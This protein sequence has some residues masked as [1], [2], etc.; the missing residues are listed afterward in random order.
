[1]Q[2][3]PQ[4]K[5]CPLSI[6]AWKEEGVCIGPPTHPFRHDCLCPKPPVKGEE[7]KV[8]P[9]HGA[10]GIEPT[11]YCKYKIGESCI[12]V[13]ICDRPAPQ[14]TEGEK[15][16]K[17]ECHHNPDYEHDEDQYQDEEHFCPPCDCPPQVK[18]TPE[19]GKECEEHDYDNTIRLGRARHICP[20]CGKNV[21]LELAL[22]EEALQKSSSPQPESEG[23]ETERLK[24]LLDGELISANA[25]ASFLVVLDE[26][27][28]QR[29][30]EVVE[31]AMTRIADIEENTMENKNGELMLRYVDVQNALSSLETDLSAKLKE[32]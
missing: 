27:R 2:H 30:K 24:E 31:E 6:C 19:A 9:I 21:T 26:A 23:W 1:M 11:H 17:V 5:E 18:P 20:K 14:T 28:L 22:M 25:L 12:C 16:H 13:C 10:P 8:C 29:T 7:K 32:V 15:K 3:N 4:N